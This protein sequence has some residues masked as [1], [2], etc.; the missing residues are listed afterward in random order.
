[1]SR[2]NSKISEPKWQKK[3]HESQIFRVEGRNQRKVLCIGNVPL[4]FR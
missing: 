2:Y 4:P 1:M 3:W